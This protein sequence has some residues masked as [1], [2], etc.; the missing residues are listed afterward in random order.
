MQSAGN[1]TRLSVTSL[2]FHSLH[3]KTMAPHLVFSPGESQGRRAGW[4]VCGVPQSG[5]R[6]KRVAAAAG[7][8]GVAMGEM[9]G[10]PMRLLGKCGCGGC[11]VMEKQGEKGCVLKR[12][13]GGE[14]RRGSLRGFPK[15]RVI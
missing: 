4:A 14:A 13:G 7:V 10:N 6:L 1:W 15:L 5:T 9:I 3:W 11:G 8:C 2:T 12:A